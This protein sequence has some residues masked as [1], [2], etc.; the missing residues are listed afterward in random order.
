MNSMLGLNLY[1]K[2]QYSLFKN[3]R[4]RINIPVISPF[5]I[6]RKKAA[7]ICIGKELDHFQDHSILS[8][9]K[10]E[11]YR[12]FKY[13]L[14]VQLTSFRNICRLASASEIRKAK[15]LIYLKCLSIV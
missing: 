9:V 15:M 8:K 1:F 3:I 14:Q 4:F 2:V 12:F 6:L 5:R 7:S 13:N 11:Y 10:G